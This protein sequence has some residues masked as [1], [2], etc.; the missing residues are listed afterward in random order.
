MLD[1]NNSEDHRL[2]V[3][4]IL[5]FGFLLMSCSKND[6]AE[7]MTDVLAGYSKLTGTVSGS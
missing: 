4:M 6:V 3:V 2:I 5:A 7:S 1:N